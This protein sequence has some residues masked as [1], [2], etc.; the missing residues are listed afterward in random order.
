MRR[1]NKNITCCYLHPITKY[2]Y[3]PAAGETLK[4]IGEMASIGFQ[5]VELEGIRENHLLEV[6]S[7]R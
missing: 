3:P 6:H 1:I 2:G 4:Y 7:M 5:S